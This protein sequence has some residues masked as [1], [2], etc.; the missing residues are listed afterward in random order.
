MKIKDI[1]RLLVFF[2]LLVLISSCASLTRTSKVKSTSMTPDYVRFDLYNDDF[3]LLGEVEISYDA[4]K[5][6]GIFNYLDS[7][8]NEY[9]EPRIIEKVNIEGMY[10]ISLNKFMKR[11]AVKVIE[12]FPGAD[13][14]VP[15][16]SKMTVQQMFLGRRYNEKMIIRAYKLKQE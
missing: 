10:D 3:E 15:L 9:V 4:R 2:A 8:N 6:L 12:E 5:Y 16:Y 14:Y 11:A 7:L 1:S 13:Y